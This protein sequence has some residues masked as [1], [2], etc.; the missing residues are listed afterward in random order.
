MKKYQDN[1]STRDAG[2]PDGTSPGTLECIQEGCWRRGKTII[3][4]YR[5]ARGDSR[6]P[7][8]IF[9]HQ[10]HADRSSLF[11]LVQRPPPFSQPTPI[12][13]SSPIPSSALPT[14][15]SLTGPT[16]TLRSFQRKLQYRIYKTMHPFS[17]TPK[18]SYSKLANYY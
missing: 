17:T 3:G 1:P 13:E 2:D 9:A 12:L 18:I 4:I 11:G 6:H 10:V 16:T 15:S 14:P 7:E 8:N 5:E